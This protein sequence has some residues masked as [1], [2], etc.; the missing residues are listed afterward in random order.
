MIL[1]IDVHYSNTSAT[2]GGVLFNDWPDANPSKVFTCQLENVAFY[3]AGNFYKRELPCILALIDRYALKVKW[4][5]I[6]GYVYL[7]SDS[8]P[9]LGMYLFEALDGQ[10]S[11]V[12]VA[13]NYFRGTSAQ[14]IIIRGRSTK[15][16]YVTSTEGLE[17]AKKNIMKM[18]G[19]F[20]IPTLLKQV[21]QLCRAGYL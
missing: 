20:R 11:I 17:T 13:K 14:H 19:E 21:D 15:P 2:A 7:G 8:K 18:H 9:G 3:E 1:A 6:D 10:S 4:I 12:G 16:L 5:V